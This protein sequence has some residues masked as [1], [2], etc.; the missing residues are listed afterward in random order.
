MQFRCWGSGQ[1]NPS[2]DG[3]IQYNA[4]DYSS[5]QCIAGGNGSG[6]CNPGNDGS[7]QY[8]AGGDGLIQHNTGG[9]GSGQDITGSEG[10][11]ASTRTITSSD[12]L[13][14]T[15]TSIVLNRTIIYSNVLTRTIITSISLTIINTKG[16]NVFSESKKLCQWVLCRLVLVGDLHGYPTTWPNWLAKL[17]TL[18][19]RPTPIWLGFTQ[20]TLCFVYSSHPLTKKIMDSLS[21][22]IVDFQWI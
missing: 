3:Y 8:I 7:G 12:A 1:Y 6:R 15:N 2:V 9:D 21:L 18:L 4:G 16:L 22:G 14:I 20:V 10:R 5:C 13:T 17:A 19:F 11:I